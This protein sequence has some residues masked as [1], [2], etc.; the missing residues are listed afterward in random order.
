MRTMLSA[1]HRMPQPPQRACGAG[2]DSASGGFL[3]C[4]ALGGYTYL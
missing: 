3:S 1:Q 2:A 4:S